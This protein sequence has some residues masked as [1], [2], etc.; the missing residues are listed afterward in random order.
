M[1][2]IYFFGL[3]IE[4]KIT[5]IVAAL[6][7]SPHHLFTP[8]FNACSSPPSQYVSLIRFMRQSSHYFTLKSALT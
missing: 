7:A 1:I 8:R 4:R 3:R 2:T 5:V 6:L